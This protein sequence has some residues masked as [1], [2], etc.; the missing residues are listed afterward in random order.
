MSKKKTAL[1]LWRERMGLTQREAAERLGFA[2]ST[3]QRQ[4]SERSF[5]TGNRVPTPLVTLL[6]AAALEKYPRLKPIKGEEDN[7]E[8]GAE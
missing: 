5:D 1:L 6:A 7:E 2:L 8:S 4:E 3:Y